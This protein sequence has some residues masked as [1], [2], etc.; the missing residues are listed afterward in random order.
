MKKISKWKWLFLIV[1][2]ILISVIIY[3][4]ASVLLLILIEKN[5]DISIANIFLTTKKYLTQ[6]SILNL[7]ICLVFLVCSISYFLGFNFFAKYRKSESLIKN[8]NRFIIDKRKKEFS[9]KI[10]EKNFEKEIVYSTLVPKKAGAVVRW[11]V[12]KNKQIKWWVAN[13]NHVKVI[14]TTGGGKSQFMIIPNI[15]YNSKLPEKEKPCLVIVDPKGE[16]YQNT[17]N[18]L[19][20]EGYIVQRI[21][22]DKAFNSLGWN[23]LARI[24]DLFMSNNIELINE[25]NKEFNFLLGTIEL[26]QLKKS[27]SPIWPI[28]SKSMIR[29]AALVLIE[30]GKMD[31]ISKKEFNFYNLKTLVSDI[32]LINFILNH[33]SEIKQIREINAEYKSI[34]S[35]PEAT[36]GSFLANASA[37]LEIFNQ[38]YGIQS[39][40]LRDEF[41]LIKASRCSASEKPIAVF[42]S[43]PDNDSTN[44]A[45]VSMFIAQF[46]SSATGQAKSNPDL[47]LERRLQFIIDEFGILVPIPEFDNWMNISRSRNI[48]FLNALQN[49]NQIKVQYPI[50]FQSIINGF[51]SNIFISS[52]DDKD[53]EALSK[54]VGKKDVENIS[55]SKNDKN[56][57]S[58]NYSV[59][60][61]SLISVDELNKLG[62]FYVLETTSK[63][64]AILKK[65]LAYKYFNL[66]ATLEQDL[67]GTF[68]DFDLDNFR[69]DFDSM[70]TFLKKEAFEKEKANIEADISEALN[71]EDEEELEEEESNE[72]ILSE[73]QQ[74][75][76]K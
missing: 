51:N 11:E 24:W 73:I 67:V 38:D 53:H 15:I 48:F 45:L 50:T 74:Q 56:K 55:I 71:Q 2:V 39:L 9:L 22:F 41:D 23:P 60:E 57:D 19:K 61:E 63:P 47:K 43:Y 27:G 40:L 76:N 66:D 25:G 6:I 29:V 31:K 69:V 21:N 16:L 10:D 64:A 52:K 20:N 65:S 13:E 12:Q 33:Y 58:K 3:L 54:R 18:I 1:G 37:A 68:Q 36:I 75:I 49:D 8:K 42:I 30:L 32:E 72:D 46:Y 35:A 4:I 26:L 59:K 14:A 17:A 70:I 34:L 28:G 62:D 7:I 44:N 5:L